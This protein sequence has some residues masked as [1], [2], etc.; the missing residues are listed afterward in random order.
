MRDADDCAM[1]CRA[2]NDDV[3]GGGRSKSG[4]DPNVAQGFFL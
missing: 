1:Q 2:M 4:K 3:D